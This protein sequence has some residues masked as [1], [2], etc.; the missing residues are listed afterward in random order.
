M[1]TELLDKREIRI[2]GMFGAI[3]PWYDTLNHLLSLNVDRSW[4]RRTTRLAPPLGNDPILE[5]AR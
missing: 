1:S 5:N 2:R 4:R 3:A